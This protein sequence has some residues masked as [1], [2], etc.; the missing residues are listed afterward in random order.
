MTTQTKKLIAIFV[1]TTITMFAVIKAFGEVTKVN[2]S[3]GFS[4]YYSTE[5][6]NHH[7]LVLNNVED[8]CRFNTSWEEIMAEERPQNVVVTERTSHPSSSEVKEDILK[9]LDITGAVYMDEYYRDGKVWTKFWRNKNGQIYVREIM[10]EI[11]D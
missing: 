7:I 11:T 8:V 1:V 10:W 4:T 2:D 9:L 5:L 6:K 3:N